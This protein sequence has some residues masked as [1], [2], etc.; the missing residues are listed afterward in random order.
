MKTK[1]LNWKKM[2]GLIPAVV[3]DANTNTVLMLGYM[4]EQA[5]KK[6]LSTKK[7][8]FYSR[9]KKRLWMK[10]EKSKNVL[11]FIEMKADCDGDAILI[12]AEPAGSTCHTGDYSCFGEDIEQKDLDSLFARIESRKTEMPKGSYTTSLFRAGLDKISLKVAEESMEVIHAAQKETRGRLI[13]ESVD[14]LYHLFVLLVQKKVFLKE[15]GAEIK[16]RAG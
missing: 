12:K 6:T 4:N 14:L 7:V 2:D 5:L 16:K 1:K 9:S 8:W 11:N 3:Q 10:G 15:I 13:E